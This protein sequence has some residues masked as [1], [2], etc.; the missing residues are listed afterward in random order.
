MAT[1]FNKERDESLMTKLIV[2]R[3]A[4]AATA[5]GLSTGTT[6][7]LCDTNEYNKCTYDHR[8]SWAIVSEG[9]AQGPYTAIP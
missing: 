2:M 7:Q 1:D 6:W 5:Y 4:I 3:S 8:W 9:P